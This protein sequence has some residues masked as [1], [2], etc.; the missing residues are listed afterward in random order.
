MPKHKSARRD[1]VEIYLHLIW[2]TWDRLPLITPAW[3]DELYFLLRSRAQAVGCFPMAS[4]GMPD[5]V[6]LLVGISSTTRVCDLL[7]DLKGTSAELGMRHCDFFK[8]RRTYA[9]YSVSRWDKEMIANYCL[10]QKVHH[11]NHTTD[12]ELE[13]ADEEYWFEDMRS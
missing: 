1:K 11:A 10:N 6:H 9:A 12:D 5:H 8:W 13:G 2:T 4:G 7:R 3:E